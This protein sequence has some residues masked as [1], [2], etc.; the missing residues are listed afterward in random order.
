MQEVL[1]C[2]SPEELAA[3]REM[4]QDSNYRKDADVSCSHT[5]KYIDLKRLKLDG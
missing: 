5:E 2:Y 3:L 1:D 4:A